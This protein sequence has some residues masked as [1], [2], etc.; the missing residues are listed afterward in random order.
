MRTRPALLFL[1]FPI[2]ALLAAQQ[3]A[4]MPAMDRG[5]DVGHV[6]WQDDTGG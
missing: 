6:I 5:L 2:T 3:T 4:D 1:L